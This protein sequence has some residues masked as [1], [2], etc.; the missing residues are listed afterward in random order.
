LD[1]L[2]ASSLHKDKTFADISGDARKR[3]YQYEIC[4]RFLYTENTKEVEDAFI[5]LNKFTMPLKAQELRN[6]VYHGPFVKLSEKLADDE[7]WAVNRIV[8]PAA[9]RRMADI[10]MISDLLI[11][12]L[13]GPQGGS[14]KVIDEYYDKYEAYEEVFPNQNRIHRLFEKTR[15][16]IQR[17]FP[18]ISESRW[19]NR[20]DYYSLL[21]ALGQLLEKQR[22]PSSNV[23]ALRNALTD[24]A[25]EV[26]KRLGDPTA[27][28][29]AASKAY[30]RA[31][32]KG[33]NDKARRADRHDQL[34]TIIGQFL[35]EK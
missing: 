25:D 13:H 3:F 26:D 1:A 16:T 21:I 7:Y 32:E 24:F 19:G 33:S 17:L 14:A 9:I 29:S 35:V 12:L 8:T 18:E 22:L 2:P 28:T 11:G 30:A 5:R 23:K 31:I 34:G 10:E 27:K 4:V 20:A 6:A 15:Q